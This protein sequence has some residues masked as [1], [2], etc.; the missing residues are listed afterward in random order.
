MTNYKLYYFNLDAR[1]EL[2]RLLFAYGGIKY[3]DIR[4]SFDEWPKVKESGPFPF[5]QMPVLE[6]DG[7]PICQSNAICRHLARVIGIDGKNETEKV[8]IDMVAD[9]CTYEIVEKAYD[10]RAPFAEPDENKRVE[11]G[12]VFRDA[13]LEPFL[14]N[15]D[16][17]YQKIGGKYFVSDEITYAD[18]AYYRMINNVKP[19]LADLPTPHPKLKDLYARISENEKLKEWEKN[20]A[21]A[22]F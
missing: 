16:N 19:L 3:E 18:L 15:L 4:Y 9:S 17:L 14:I 2:I 12:K 8:L 22:I 1:A 13:K 10:H 6:V 7:K 21:E 20:K 11:K 5:K